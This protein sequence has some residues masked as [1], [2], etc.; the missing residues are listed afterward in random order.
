MN[1][2]IVPVENQ[3][4]QQEA[5]MK[6]AWTSMSDY[7]YMSGGNM[8]SHDRLEYMRQRADEDYRHPVSVITSQPTNIQPARQ[9]YHHQQQHQQHMDQYMQGE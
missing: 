3:Q 5:R 7:P 6:S 1:K 2:N 4:Q 8:S 9:M